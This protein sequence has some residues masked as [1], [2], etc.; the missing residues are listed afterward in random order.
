M[1]VSQM[2]S[3]LSPH[4][5]PEGSCGD[6]YWLSEMF[7]ASERG[8]EGSEQNE[9]EKL[10]SKAQ[11]K[12]EKDAK[13]LRKLDSDITKWGAAQLEKRREYR[14]LHRDEL[15]AYNYEY[16][17]HHKRHI[18]EYDRRYNEAHPEH[19]LRMQADRLTDLTGEQYNNKLIL[20]DGR[21][22]V[23]KMSELEYRRR[24][25][26]S[27]ADDHDHKTG[28]HRG[29]LC[30]GCNLTLGWI[31]KKLGTFKAGFLEKNYPQFVPYMEEYHIGVIEV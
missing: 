3:E 28:F 18:A 25:G 5:V 31:E 29:L 2:Q 15:T 22:A 17:S 30:R 9:A 11:L 16:R 20:Q 23:C 27:F 7:E 13:L 10:K 8:R 1:L 6:A 24:T 26:Y 14:R 19:V 4:C 21:C 12:R